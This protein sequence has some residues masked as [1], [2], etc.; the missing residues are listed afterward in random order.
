MSGYWLLEWLDAEG[1]A[2]VGV[3]DGVLRTRQGYERMLHAADEARSVLPEPPRAGKSLVAGTGLDLSG[4]LGCGRAAC[5]QRTIE[6][7]VQR[8][9]CYFDRVIVTGL[10]PNEFLMSASNDKALHREVFVN[11]ASAALHIRDIGAQE[12]FTF[13]RKA[14][15]CTNHMNKHA[16]EA[17]MSA[18]DETVEALTEELL[19]GCEVTLKETR[20]GLQYSFGHPLLNTTLVGVMQRRMKKPQVT[21]LLAHRRANELVSG[22]TRSVWLCREVHGALGQS[23]L[24]ASKVLAVPRSGTLSVP[25]VAV[26][27]ELPALD[28][29]SA[30]DLLSLRHDEPAEFDAFRGALVKTIEER[31]RAL[32]HENAAQVGQS[33]VDDVLT[34]AIAGLELRMQRSARLLGARSAAAVTAGG[35]LTTIGLLA[36]AP[37]AVPGLVLAS[38]GLVA[39]YADFLKDRRDVDLSDLHFLW[40]ADK[41]LHA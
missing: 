18:M 2:D 23:A 3:I 1:I 38:G 26:T 6:D 25:D 24:R 13:R 39:N 12:L 9:W 33:V 32:P 31:I 40:R 11:H 8:S 36:F 29:A 41:T 27:L 30:R 34:P 28:G 20:I 4:V 7:L 21:R 22:L 35:L 17:G 16:A 5:L 14:Q 10:D 15:L 19:K 37:L